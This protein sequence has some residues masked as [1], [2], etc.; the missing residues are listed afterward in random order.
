MNFIKFSDLKEK[1]WF[2]QILKIIMKPEFKLDKMLFL[3]Q[4]KM[5][6]LKI[7]VLSFEII[8]VKSIFFSC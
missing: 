2:Y 6:K 8:C 3:N 4:G 5:L 7:L 1:F